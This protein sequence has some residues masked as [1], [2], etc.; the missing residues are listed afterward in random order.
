MLDFLPK[1]ILSKI[2]KLGNKLPL[3]NYI[4]LIKENI[5]NEYNTYKTP[6]IIITKEDDGIEYV[7]FIITE[8]MNIA[9]IV[10]QK[11]VS[12]FQKDIMELIKKNM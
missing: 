7:S 12:E 6:D 5:K 2:I 9:E 8:G 1:P 10:I 11:T 3:E 4:S